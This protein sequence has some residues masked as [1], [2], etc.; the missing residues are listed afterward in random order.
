M[1]KY[2]MQ[3]I[4]SL[5]PSASEKQFQLCLMGN[6]THFQKRG[7]CHLKLFMT[8]RSWSKIFSKEHIP[9][10]DKVQYK[11]VLVK[12]EGKKTAVLS[13]ACHFRLNHRHY[14]KWQALRKCQDSE[15]ELQHQSQR[16]WE[17]LTR[18]EVRKS[19]QN[20]CE[21]TKLNPEQMW[22]GHAP[23]INYTTYGVI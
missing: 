5:D 10:S 12:E 20:V 2:I 13:Y 15:V 3:T 16:R 11:L 18:Q 22:M 8:M 19:I 6:H 7:S 14:Q 23:F 4:N 21:Y 9:G 1:Y 17:G